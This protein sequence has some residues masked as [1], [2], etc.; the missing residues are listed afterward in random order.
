M[1]TFMQRLMWSKHIC[2]FAMGP[3]YSQHLQQSLLV[4]V[5]NDLAISLEW[6][7][8]MCFFLYK[9]TF[10]THVCTVW[11]DPNTSVCSP[12]V[13]NTPTTSGNHYWSWYERIWPYGCC[14]RLKCVFFG[15]NTYLKLIY[16]SYEVIQTHLCIRHGSIILVARKAIIIG[17]G[18][19]RFGHMVVV[20][21][22]NVLFLVQIHIW[23]TF[24]HR[25]TWSEHICLFAMGPEYSHHIRQSL[26]VLVR[27]DLTIWLLWETQMCFFWYK[28]VFETH[29]CI[30]WGDPNTFVYSPWVHNTRST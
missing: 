27:K 10:E 11:G 1:N 15:T 5:W 12:W 20:G 17:L 29:L 9:Y 23:N 4:L 2:R 16:A 6:E 28:Y 21:D 7:S 26:L 18:M 3:E 13:Q 8:H 19:K 25:L 30:V 24:M 22:S 14:G